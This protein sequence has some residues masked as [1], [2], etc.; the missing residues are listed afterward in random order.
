MGP[1]TADITGVPQ[2]SVAVPASVMAL[3]AV[4]AGGLQPKSKVVEGQEVKT[5]FWVSNTF[6]S[7]LHVELQLLLP[8][9]VSVKIN[10]SSQSAPAVIFTLDPLLAPE[11]VPF[12][13]MFHR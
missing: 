1:P 13:E 9:T 11:M 10:V 2:L 6:T 4:M 5:G 8:V 3:A 7:L 12:P